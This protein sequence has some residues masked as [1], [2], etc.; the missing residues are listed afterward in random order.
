[1]KIEAA[2]EK[3]ISLLPSSADCTL[4]F[5]H[6]WILALLQPR[7][8][9]TFLFY[10]LRFQFLT[11]FVLLRARLVWVGCLTVAVPPRT[12]R[13][14]YRVCSCSSACYRTGSFLRRYGRNALPLLFCWTTF[15]S[16]AVYSVPV[17]LPAFHLG[18]RRD[19]IWPVPCALPA[20]LVDFRLFAIPFERF[21]LNGW[22]D[23]AVSSRLP[24]VADRIRFSL[25]ASR[26]VCLEDR[27][28]LTVAFT[29]PALFAPGG[30][31]D[32]QI[33]AFRAGSRRWF[34]A[35]S[36]CVADDRSRCIRLPHYR[37]IT[38]FAA[39]HLW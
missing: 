26:F 15:S 20:V 5:P 33:F 19:R 35:G 16:V 7:P 39:M 24:R 21:F 14:H 34:N 37:F 13:L 4:Q 6:T 9:A 30:F 3:D 1:V 10:V 36:L 28:G 32:L 17:L 29:A 38:R 31:L 8:F 12:Y 22:F 2:E 11:A 25:C 23:I 27:A 18:L